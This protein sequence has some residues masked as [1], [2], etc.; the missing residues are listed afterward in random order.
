M[1][2]T[3]KLVVEGDTSDAN[4][5]IKKLGRTLDRAFDSAG[6]KVGKLGQDVRKEL[7]EG[8]GK[9]FLS[10][11]AAIGAFNTVLGVAQRVV[12]T[13]IDNASAYFRS[14]EKLR[15]ALR[16]TSFDVEQT[17]A[18]LNDQSS[19]LQN[20]TGVSDDII[21]SL[22]AQAIAQGVAVREVDGFV[23]A[24]FRLSNVTG[25]SVE[26]AFRQLLKTLSGLAGELGEANPKIRE[27]TKEQLRAGE[28]VR[29]LNDEYGEFLDINTRGL[30]GELLRLGNAFDDLTEAVIVRIS[31][32][33]NQTV[34]GIL[35]EELN[36]LTTLVSRGGITDAANLL[37]QAFTKIFF[38]LPGAQIANKQLNDILRERVEILSAARELGGD[39]AP[40][41]DTGLLPQQ[42]A[43]T[44]GVPDLLARP[45]LGEG[46]PDLLRRPRDQA[47]ER[48]QS[49]FQAQRLELERTVQDGLRE[50]QESNAIR[51]EEIALTENER[52]R[53]IY[54]EQG[55]L[56]LAEEI[57]R[58]QELVSTTSRAASIVGSFITQAISGALEGDFN[59]S[60]FVKQFLQA[61][62]T[63]L[64]ASGIQ[65]ALF[66]AAQVFIPGLQV[67]GAGLNTVGLAEIAA[68][69]A[70]LG[71]SIAI[72]SAVRGAGAGR[73]AATPL[74]AFGGASAAG[75]AATGGGGGA[76]NIT[77]VF[78]GPTT[79]PEVGVA[80][81]EAL[82][83]ANALGV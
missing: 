69:T 33:G 58:Q 67:T 15:A 81:R 4:R 40:G 65:H 2:I 55:K 34:I 14:T 62:G 29:L 13:A 12:G 21:R 79:R 24:A 43:A 57:D 39:L 19:A 73:S 52:I 27:L 10:A 51:R 76:Q 1:A 18:A 49:S 53:Q 47:P 26:G 30:P 37:G 42:V 78:N 72:P 16:G 36:E 71:G 50:I 48:A 25:Q 61:T 32:E 66:G 83:E 11:S 17:S 68:G 6:Q 44:V 45:G 20:L 35:A 70:M 63:Q 74:P 7:T 60:E 75:G 64:I 23:R 80:I 77:I 46:V 54:D 22:Q 3:E 5:A 8:I 28:A 56:L 41:P 9:S 82:N 38:F 59:F 31:P